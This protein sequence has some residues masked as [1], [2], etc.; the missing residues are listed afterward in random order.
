[1]WTRFFESNGFPALVALVSILIGVGVTY[2]TA[3]DSII[4]AASASDFIIFGSALLLLCII[5]TAK[6]HLG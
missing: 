3:S 6:D 1:M 4:F 2:C 5:G